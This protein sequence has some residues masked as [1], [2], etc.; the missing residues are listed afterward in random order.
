MPSIDYLQTE[1]VVPRT[2]MKYTGEGGYCTYRCEDG[3]VNDY[4]KYFC[5]VGTL[6]IATTHLE[7]MKE[8]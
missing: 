1:G 5:K 8:I 7:M 2:C 3:T 4:K 6:H